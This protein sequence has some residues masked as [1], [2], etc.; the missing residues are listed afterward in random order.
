MLVLSLILEIKD[1]CSAEKVLNFVTM[2]LNFCASMV[3]VMDTTF[4]MV[5]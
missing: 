4:N 3:Q 1:N 5:N 2:Y